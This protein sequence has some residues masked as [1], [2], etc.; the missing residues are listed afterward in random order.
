MMAASTRASVPDVA[1]HSFG[2][3]VRRAAA[4]A[5]MAMTAVMIAVA[6]K[7]RKRTCRVTIAVTPGDFITVYHLMPGATHIHYLGES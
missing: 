2:T 7:T 4:R 1:H 6:A 3:N 5:Y